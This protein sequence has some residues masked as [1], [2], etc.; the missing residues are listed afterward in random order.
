MSKKIR[1]G[2]LGYGTIG[3]GVIRMLTRSDLEIC[4]RVELVKVADLDLE[5]QREVAC[6]P[7]LLTRDAQSVVTDPDI[8]VIIELIGGIGAAK[9]LV[10]T[11]LAA[12]KDVI[13]ANK[14][15][16]SR[17]GDELS[18]IAAASGARLLFEASVA[19][20]IPI[21]KVLREELV[22]DEVL[23]ISAILNGTCNYI[24]TR[25]EQSPGLSCKQAVA[26]A[27]KKG[28][29]EA[30]PTLDIS[31]MDTA[32][33]LSILVRKAFR[34]RVLPESI[35]LQGIT[36]V[37]N[38]DVQ[39][40][41][42]MGFRIK[43][44]ARASRE[45]G[46]LAVWVGPTLI[47]ADSIMAQVRNE[48][49]AVMVNCWAHNEHTY[50]GKGAGM[51]PTAGAVISDLFS[52]TEDRRIRTSFNE[53]R[54]DLPVLAREDVSGR[55]YLRVNVKDQPGV[56]ARISATLAEHGISIAS[57][58]QKE[59]DTEPKHGV[60]LVIITHRTTVGA[61]TK[62]AKQIDKEPVVL[63]PSHLIRIMD[64]L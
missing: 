3:S 9:T 42:E 53:S 63:V 15:L 28:F 32:Q 62:A 36:E 52:L 1:V 48:F 57:V 64:V 29:A 59:S 30:D 34:T 21:I 14:Y 8:D 20:G 19:G 38:V 54:L 25:M 58:V 6:D 13:T 56:F 18:E 60:P 47:P 4:K 49:N 2:L 23:S 16:M 22:A 31:G 37:S 17:Y 11:A 41:G 35:D 27:Q 44:L 61:V 55:F 7:K 26:E 51:M 39:A 50:I 46:H 12:G 24:L 33:K 40:A 43:L 10:E 45:N 5:R